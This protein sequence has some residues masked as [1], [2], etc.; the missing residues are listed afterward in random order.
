MVKPF[1]EL[2]KWTCRLAF[3]TFFRASAI[4]AHKVPMEGRVILAG[5]HTSYL[6]PPLIGCM[7]NR[8]AYYMARD[9]L[10]KFPLIRQALLRMNAIPV[11]REGRS[12]SGLKVAMR[13]IKNEQCLVLFPEGTRSRDGQRQ[14][15]KNGLGMMVVKTQ[16][17][18]SPVRVVGTFEAYGRHITIPRPRKVS[19]YYG[20]ILDFSE[21]IQ[22]A[23]SAP[24]SRQKAIYQEIT[25]QIMEAIFS[26]PD[27]HPGKKQE[28]DSA[29]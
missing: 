21:L 1:Y 23:G 26:L 27:H 28:P 19:V 22:E 4:G 3:W 12:S 7:I 5:N 16:T 25:D 29:N 18:V 17:R 13:A 8:P 15:V 6:D 24:T 14:P 9:S 20:D 10:F 11:D 2:S